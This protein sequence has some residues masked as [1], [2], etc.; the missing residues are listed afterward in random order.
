MIL[1][2]VVVARATD[3]GARSARRRRSRSSAPAAAIAFLM[4][5]TLYDVMSFPHGP[6]IFLYLSGLVAVAVT[7]RVRTASEPIHPRP[8]R[9]RDR[10]PGAH[11][12]RMLR[13]VERQR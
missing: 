9:R 5:A 12:G 7:Q 1:S 11:P 8:V 2:V 10:R 6:Y 4:A 3:R 13:D